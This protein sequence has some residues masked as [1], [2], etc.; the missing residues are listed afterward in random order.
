MGNLMLTWFARGAEASVARRAIIL[1]LFVYDAIALVVTLIFVLTGSLNPLGWGIVAV[2]HCCGLPVFHDR[3]R[4]FPAS[5]KKDGLNAKTVGRPPTSGRRPTIISCRVFFR[6]RR[7]QNPTYFAPANAGDGAPG[8][9]V[10][11]TGLLTYS[12]ASAKEDS[13]VRFC[14]YTL[15]VI[16]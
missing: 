16:R 1:H 7:N 15:S 3:L 10:R 8:I 11:S 14:G 13:I 5:A 12:T 4:L 9:I 2:Y 6:S